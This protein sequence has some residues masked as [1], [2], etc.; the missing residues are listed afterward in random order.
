[1]EKFT[2]KGRSNILRPVFLKYSY[3]LEKGW[4]TLESV[5]CDM[6]RAIEPFNEQE[7]SHM[8][9][10]DLSRSYAHTN[11]IKNAIEGSE[12]EHLIK[13]VPILSFTTDLI[14]AYP[15]NWKSVRRGVIE[16]GIWATRRD[17]VKQIKEH[18]KNSAANGR[19]NRNFNH[20]SAIGRLSEGLANDK[21]L[22]GNNKKHDPD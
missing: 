16:K 13:Q 8:F 10:I 11:V 3:V 21:L 18:L 20:N 7:I 12:V 19:L 14:K 2:A 6:I 5:F 22:R 4:V 15:T 9:S 17:D 1:M